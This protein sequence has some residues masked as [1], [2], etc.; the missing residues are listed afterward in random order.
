[1]R[2]GLTQKDM[3]YRHMKDFGSITSWEAFQDY[4]VTRLS[5]VIF[6]LKRNGID[7][8]VNRRSHINRY[9]DKVNFAEYSLG[10]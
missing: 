2:N 5:A 7:I 9:G 4:G 10:Y 6:E 1:M 3:I 8:D